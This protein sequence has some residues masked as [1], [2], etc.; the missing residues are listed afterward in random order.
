MLLLLQKNL[1]IR[2]YGFFSN[3]CGSDVVSKDLGDTLDYTCTE[4][5]VTEKF[6]LQTYRYF[7]AT[8]KATVYIHCDLRV[9]LADEADSACECP[10]DPNICN[11]AFPVTRK[12]RKRRS[13]AD[14]VNE[15]RLYHVVSGPYTF[16]KEEV[17]KE[18]GK[19]SLYYYQALVRN[20][21]GFD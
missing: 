3:R 10:S 5:N 9:C 19:Y 2:L 20:S 21:L 16:K 1:F 13:I 18:E 17:N 11:G 15:S 7:E 4:N 8:D 6:S 12:R 14:S